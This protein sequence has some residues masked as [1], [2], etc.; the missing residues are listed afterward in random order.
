MADGREE[1]KRSLAMGLAIKG[2]MLI[3]FV[4][5]LSPSALVEAQAISESDA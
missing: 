1:R 3:A 5:A 2:G 4:I